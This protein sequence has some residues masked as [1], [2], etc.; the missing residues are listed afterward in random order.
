M[1]PLPSSTRPP[2]DRDLR[3]LRIVADVQAGWSYAAIG[4]REGI[5]RERVRQ[6]VAQALGEE[7]AGTKLDHARVQMARLEPAL[8]LAAQAVADGDLAGI[9]R[10]IRVLDRLDKYSAVEDAGGA[11]DENARERLLTKLNT[12]AERMRAARERGTVGPDGRPAAASEAGGLD[13]ADD[14][15]LAG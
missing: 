3:R 2:R 8:R 13:E 11:Y 12:M 15:D 10:L 7:G 14:V 4:R 1:P 9:D 5:S 6:I